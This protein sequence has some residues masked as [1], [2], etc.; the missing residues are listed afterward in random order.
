MT[1]KQQAG[2]RNPIRLLMHVPVPWVFVLTYLVGAGLEVAH[3]SYTGAEPLPGVSVAGGVVFAIGAAIAAWSLV[4]FHRART[5][6]VPGRTSA[7]LVTWGPYRLSRNPMYVGLVL[8]YLGEAGILKQVWPV[9]LLPLTLAYINRVVIP[10]E[11]ARLTEV[12]GGEY[13][14]YRMKVRRWI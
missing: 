3:R 8:A 2:G 12:F 9:V 11:E 5:T 7:K 1:N 6:T 14:Q 13:E 10:V 4:I